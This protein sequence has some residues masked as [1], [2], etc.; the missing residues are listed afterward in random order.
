MRIILS[1]LFIGCVFSHGQDS[2]VVKVPVG[3]CTS[4]PIFT[5]GTTG[6]VIK[7]NSSDL[8]D[9]NWTT[10]TASMVGL[11]SVDNT[12]DAAKPVSTATQTALNLKAN[13]SG[14]TFTGSIGYASG[15]GGTVT[16]A[17]NKSTGVTLNKQCGQ[18]T[19][20]GAALA[21]AAE[22]AFTLTNNTIASTDVVI[23]NVQSV[24]TAGAYF[25]TVG[26]VGNGSCSIT[27]GNAS[28][29]S[30][31]QAIVLNFCILKGVNN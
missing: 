21:A 24:G 29:G 1:I 3:L 4:L 20:N 13:L 2:V 9:F 30:L 26:A 16:Q 5:G 19:M 23:V 14:A 8:Y 6:Q 7:K 12:S 10:P 25:V 28:T 17:T 27:V 18:I 22:V 15:V 11:G 31:S